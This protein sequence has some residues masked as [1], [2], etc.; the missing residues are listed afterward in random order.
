M[1]VYRGGSHPSVLF[2]GEAP[3]K[4]ED[5]A[6]L[7]FVGRAGR[8]LDRAIATVGLA[9]ETVGI[10]NLIECRPPGNRFDA[11]AAATCRPFLDRQLAIL[12]PRR[13]VT[14]GRH[15]LRTLAPDAPPITKA[16]GFVRLGPNGPVFPLLHPAAPMHAPRYAARWEHD[17]SAL[18]AWLAEPLSQTS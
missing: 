17:L 1:V 6:G 7:P 13:I 3:G 2:I 9:P 5:R 15:A 18:R 4:D 14:L 11:D 10:V 8:A 12:R 16:A